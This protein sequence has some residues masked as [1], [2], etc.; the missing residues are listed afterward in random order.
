MLAAAVPGLARASFLSGDALDAAAN[1]LSWVVLV[2]VPVA[3]IG[4]FFYVHILP[5][6]IAER[7]QLP[8]KQSI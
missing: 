7:Q 1:V 6:L 5:E 8:H 4:A 2:I 3:L